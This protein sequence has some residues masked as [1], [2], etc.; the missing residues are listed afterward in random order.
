[1]RRIHSHLINTTPQMRRV[2]DS[3]SD[4]LE[5]CSDADNDQ[6]LKWGEEL[7]YILQIAA[8]F[9]RSPDEVICAQ[10]LYERVASPKSSRVPGNVDRN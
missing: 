9:D 1:M 7:R 5:C 8:S 2:R 4:R 10:V 3:D 6:Q